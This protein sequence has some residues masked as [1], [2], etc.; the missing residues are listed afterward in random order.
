[1][2]LGKALGRQNQRGAIAGGEQRRGTQRRQAENSLIKAPCYCYR[3][4]WGSSRAQRRQQGIE[5]QG[6]QGG[7]R[8]AEDQGREIVQVDAGKISSP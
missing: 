4:R 7:G 5:D 3:A 2:L 6:E 1:V 8:R